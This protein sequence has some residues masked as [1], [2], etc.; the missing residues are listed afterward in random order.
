MST[1]SCHKYSTVS[2]QSSD[3]S[4]DLPYS[5]SYYDDTGYTTTNE[6]KKISYDKLALA[7]IARRGAIIDVGAIMIKKKV[8][9]LGFNEI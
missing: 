8:K 9:V 2:I 1:E 7:S 4:V 6:K 5:E 3:I